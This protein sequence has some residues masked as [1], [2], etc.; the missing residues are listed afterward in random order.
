[1]LLFFFHVYDGR[2]SL[3][4]ERTELPDVYT[5]QA[6]AIRMSGEIL[7]DMGAKFWDGTD[8]RLE[9]ADEHGWV[10]LVLRF[11]AEERSVLT[12]TP[13]GPGAL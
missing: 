8:W 4:D 3:D 7:R 10:L 1:M 13:P 6:E 5:A 9:V 2:T 12:D 11:S